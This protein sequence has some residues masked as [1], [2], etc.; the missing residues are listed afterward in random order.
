[1]APYILIEDSFKHFGD[2]GKI[3][4]YLGAGLPVIMTN[5][6]HIASVI[7]EKKA[8][9]V[10]NDTKEDITKSII[11]VLVDKNLRATFHQNAITLAKNYEWKSV[12]D[13][14]F[15]SLKSRPGNN[16]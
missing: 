8:G 16:A 1:M 3:K 7:K 11:R 13:S 5:I 6:S 10:T 12:F 14:A 9:L 4:T 15:R 2:L